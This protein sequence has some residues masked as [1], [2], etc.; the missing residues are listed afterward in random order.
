[1]EEYSSLLTRKGI[2][3]YEYFDSIERFEEEELPPQE[4]F[5]STLTEEGVSNEDYKHAQNVWNKFQVWNLI[6][7]SINLKFFLYN[8]KM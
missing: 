4:S 1:M 7:Y 5:Y 2:Y 3:P 8:E 6:Y